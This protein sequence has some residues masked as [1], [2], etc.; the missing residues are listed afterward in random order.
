MRKTMMIILVIFLTAFLILLYPGM[1]TSVEEEKNSTRLTFVAPFAN[2]GYWGTAAS[3]VLDAGKECGINV[4]CIGFAESDAKKQIRYIKSAIYSHADAIITAGIENSDEFNEVMKMAS[5]AGIP[6]ILIDCDIE[7]SERLCYIGT[8]NFEAGCLAGNDIA[9]V[10]E[11]KGAVAIIANQQSSINQQERI[12]GFNSVIE[13]YPNLNVVTVLKGD[14]NYMMMKEQIVNMLE[15]YPQ[16]DAIFCAEGYSS[17][18][19]NQLLLNG[20][21]T[22]KNLKV[23]TFD[24]ESY[25]FENL[26]EGRIYATIQ[27]DPYTMGKMAVEYLDQYLEGQTEMDSVVYTDIQSIKKENLDQVYN[28][29]SGDVTWHT[30]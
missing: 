6:V 22:Y 7:G 2:A 28:Y 15:E 4:K 13:Q 27:Q 29:K 11:G 25:S 12:D 30:Y 3:G 10:T 20:D 24:V 23:V 1:G 26:K 5:E 17:S 21:I 8:D 9:E 14:L 16:V 19:V 18:S